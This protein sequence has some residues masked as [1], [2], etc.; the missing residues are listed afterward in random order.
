MLFNDGPG[1]FDGPQ[2][3]DQT[4]FEWVNSS[5]K[6]PCRSGR[7]TIN[8]WL[9]DYPDPP[10]GRALQHMK[11]GSRREF[12]DALFELY[13]YTLLRRQGFEL[14]PEPVLPSGS[15]PDF[16]VLCEGREICY[17]E[18]TENHGIAKIVDADEKRDRVLAELSPHIEILGHTIHVRS[19]TVGK[20][21]PSARR[22]AKLVNRWV[23]ATTAGQALPAAADD[24]LLEADERVRATVVDEKSGWALKLSLIPLSDPMHRPSSPFGVI[25]GSGMLP[26]PDDTLR[27][28]VRDKLRQH[29]DA[30]LPIVVA[31]SFEDFLTIP[32][33][34]MIA[35]SLLGRPEYCDP[36][37][38]FSMGRLRRQRNGLWTTHGGAAVA[39]CP[40][41]ITCGWCLPWCLP[42]V[43]PVLWNNPWEPL[44]AFSARWLAA[45]RS[46]EL[47]TGTGTAAEGEPPAS[48]LGI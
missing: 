47:S 2:G 18:A 12:V 20:E 35:M 26:I 15:C 16:L 45:Q 13:L 43:K 44:L 39:R 8:R 33:D 42:D 14:V 1:D 36:R 48:I 28:E 34:D 6:P 10:R 32:D 5:R 17:L 31:V 37:G 30:Q 22:F 23:A 41:V 38:A 11:S 40:A 27:R 7:R 3:L 25:G 21:H 29:K 9:A 46:W 4:L 24:D 19:F